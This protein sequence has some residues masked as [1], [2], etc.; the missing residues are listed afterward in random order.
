MLEIGPPDEASDRSSCAEKFSARLNA[1]HFA[2]LPG[3]RMALD[4]VQIESVTT[5]ERAP[6]KDFGAARPT[7]QDVR[8]FDGVLWPRRWSERTLAPAIPG[9][10]T[11][12]ALMRKNAA[13][14]ADGRCA[15]ER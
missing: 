6:C 9:Q 5:P 14:V 2:R 10:P 15:R 7:R 8:P 13:Y 4:R 1:N 3:G 12:A 11:T